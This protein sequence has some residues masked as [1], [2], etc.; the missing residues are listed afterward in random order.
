M[1]FQEILRADITRYETEQQ[2]FP[3]GPKEEQ[4]AKTK[5]DLRRNNLIGEIFTRYFPEVKRFR[6]QLNKAA[7]EVE[8]KLLSEF[9]KKMSKVKTVQNAWKQT[10][11][12]KQEMPQPVSPEHERS[13]NL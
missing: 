12:S 1:S 2:Q 8:F 11:E 10:V 5:I 6:P 3:L 9:L 7:N 4:P 13:G